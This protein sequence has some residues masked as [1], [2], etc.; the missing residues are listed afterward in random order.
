MTSGVL[1]INKSV[2]ESCFDFKIFM[3]FFSLLVVNNGL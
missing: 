3:H 1:G 2:M